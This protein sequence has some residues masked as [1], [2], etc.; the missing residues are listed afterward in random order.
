ML[1]CGVS[2][3]T[4]A[5]TLQFNFMNEGID[6]KF[7]D[8]PEI[9]QFELKK[10]NLKFLEGKI[11]GN[12]IIYVCR[13][14]FRDIHCNLITKGEKLFGNQNKKIPKEYSIGYLKNAIKLAS[15]DWMKKYKKILFSSESD[16]KVNLYFRYA[17]YFQQ[18][19]KHGYVTE[20]AVHPYFRVK[21]F[22]GIYTNKI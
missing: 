7:N 11:F 14:K 1:M 17:K 3:K 21:Y 15:V 9:N 6:I 10:Y 18:K 22:I 19:Y 5:T 12:Y 20:I 16:D 2:D 4:I 8:L 13:D